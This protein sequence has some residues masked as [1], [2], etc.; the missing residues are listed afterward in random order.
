MR[1]LW[2]ELN[3]HPPMHHC[4][5]PYPFS[6]AAMREACNFRFE[7]Q[8]IQFLTGLN[9]QFVI[10]KAQV[11]MMDPLPSINKVY[12]LVIREESNNHS[13]ASSIEEHVSLVN[14]FESRNKPQEKERGVFY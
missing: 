3:S 8:V 6:C 12:S 13:I 4:T 5:C 10:I 7:G 14:T 11:L 2:E 9:D 1:T